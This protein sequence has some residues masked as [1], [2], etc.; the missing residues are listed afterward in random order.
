MQQNALE[1]GSKL[2]SFKE[3][4]KN[5]NLSN[6]KFKYLQ[7]SK[8][9]KVIALSPSATCLTL[10]NCGEKTFATKIIIPKA[11]LVD[12]AYEERQHTEG[13]VYNDEF[14]V[15]FG[16]FMEFMNFSLIR[17]KRLVSIV[18]VENSDSLSLQ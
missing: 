18:T 3:Y 8:H 7:K 4:S 13:D 17:D 6:G 12:Y 1:A 5:A 16:L 2:V 14:F 11:L 15:N 10:F 9:K